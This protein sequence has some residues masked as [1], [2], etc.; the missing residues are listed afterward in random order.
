MEKDLLN[1]NVKLAFDNERIIEDKIF[2]YVYVNNSTLYN[3]KIIESGLAKINKQ[4]KNLTYQNDLIQAQAYA[5]Q[6]AKG[7]WKR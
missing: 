3:E 7:I 6:L 2:A 4:A 1:Q 5:K